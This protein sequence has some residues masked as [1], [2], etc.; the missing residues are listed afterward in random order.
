MDA[1]TNERNS[2]WDRKP[3]LTAGRPKLARLTERD[4][5]V[6]KLLA[7]HPYLPLDDI[8]AFVGGSMK[9]LGQHLNLLS[10]KPNLYI[11]RPLQQRETADANYRRLIYE[12]DQPGERVLRELGL[13][14]R[15]KR[16]HRNFAHELMVCR[17]MA[18]IELGTLRSRSLRLITWAE[19]LSH[20][21][22][23]QALK[24]AQRPTYIPVSIM[25]GGQACTTE[26]SADGTPFGIERVDDNGTLLYFFFPGVEADTGTEPIESH[27]PE[28]SSIYKKFVAYRA[29]AE[30]RIYSSHFGF[31]NFFVPLV[32][33]SEPRMRSMMRCLERIVGK[34]GSAMFLFKTFPALS[35][36][37]KPPAPTGHMLIEPWERVGFPP[38]NFAE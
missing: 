34:K 33:T 38:L 10:R 31:P 18:S 8:H 19:I 5:E 27:D 12:L 21:K 14:I 25:H 35:A 9:G 20:P 11:N 3:I 24:D 26:V 37:E 6:L 32:A 36:F 22:T 15:R 4:I 7:R 28:R 29:V 2:R 30:Q 17:I 1:R 16:H 13:E 23:P